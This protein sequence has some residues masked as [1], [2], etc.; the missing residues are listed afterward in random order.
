MTL[1]GV[2]LGFFL[3][4]FI[5]G[6]TYFNDWVIGQTQLIGNHLPISVFG[7]AAFILFVLNPLLSRLAPRAALSGGEVAVMAALGLAACGWPGSNFY[8]GF[9]TVSALPSHWFKTRTAWQSN[10]VMSY[11]PGASAEVGQGQ[12]EDWPGLVRRT[13]RSRDAKDAAGQLWRSLAPEGQ[14]AFEKAAIEQPFDVGKVPTLTRALNEALKSD[15]F[16]DASVFSSS[17]AP[18]GSRREDASL[19]PHERTLRNRLALA[20]AMPDLVMRP[21]A[22]RGALLEGGRADPFVVDTLLEGRSRSNQLSV[23]AL[24]LREW[25][26]T[27][28]L[29]GSV[30]MLLAVA[31]L[32]LALI[33]HHQWSKRELLPYPIARFITEAAERQPS[34]AVPD[35]A[36]SKLFWVGFATLVL[37]HLVNG[38]HAWF[39]EIPEIP[40]KFE[41]WPLQ[42]IFPNAVRVSGQYGWFAPTVYVSVIAFS[43]FLSTSVS[44]SLGISH[45]LFFIFGATLLANGVSLDAAAGGVGKSGMMR[46]GA[47]LGVALIIAYVG[48]RYYKNV[49][50]AALGR[51]RSQETPVYAVWAARGL[52]VAIVGATVALSTSGL[53]L[54]FSAL[55]VLLCLV[56]FVV[57]TRIVT[58][59]GAFFIQTSWAPGEV[60]TA[61]FGFEALGPT[62]FVLL[63]VASVM[64]I[65]DPREMFMPFFANGLKM[66]DRKDGT[67][68]S[69]LGVAQLGVVVC[70]FAVAGLV[71]LYLQYNHSVTQ[72]GNDWGTTRLPVLA[73][74]PFAQQLAESGAKGTLG[75]A[76]H[77]SG[78]EKLGLIDPEPGALMW[79]GIGFLLVGVTAAARLRLPWW[80]LHPVAF[81][82]WDTYPI[83]MFGPSFLLGWI[84][85]ASVIGTTGLRGYHAVRPLM[86]GVIAGELLSGLFWMLVGALYFFI[87]G[88][89]PINYSI[90]PG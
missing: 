57:M 68:P 62:T 5:S 80:P 33:V 83:I 25:W 9:T 7:I 41:F 20:S 45:V 63:W 50:L 21:P 15:T 18:D 1:R 22:G 88:T 27:I 49:I 89:A 75:T 17:D 42:Q 64:L 58:E 39:N 69:R 10:Q 90:F 76:T 30:A 86:V 32:C 77:A 12:V 35:V 34:S 70:G 19:A 28:R 60:L 3:A 65:V 72:V 74:D 4:L 47:Y 13:V 81:L 46:F 82:V 71:T 8:R 59:T 87:T 66:A 61:V 43:F 6:T 84:V 23:G 37:V 67:P 48:R 73:F 36:K 31:A 40:R 53:S 56:T 14:R 11:V 29:W 55:F 2:L 54:F 16:Y 26:P 44:F 85:K 24:P 52:G 38:T 78:L 51:V 79:L